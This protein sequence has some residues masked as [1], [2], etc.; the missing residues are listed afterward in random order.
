MS[1]IIS[2]S[3]KRSNGGQNVKN[4]EPTAMPL[5]YL[6]IC[7]G[8][9]ILYTEF[10]LEFGFIIDHY[11]KWLQVYQLRVTSTLSDSKIAINNETKTNP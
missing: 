8:V 11:L 4:S 7:F 5:K 10:M 6:Q 9:T 2:I 3:K 1:L